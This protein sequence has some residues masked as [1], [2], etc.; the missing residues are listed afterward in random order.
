V[1]L[2]RSSLQE[3]E[4]PF[5]TTAPLP[6]CGPSVYVIM[7]CHREDMLSDMRSTE[8]AAATRVLPSQSVIAL[9]ARLRIDRRLGT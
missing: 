8:P 4:A 3:R 6:V 2:T 7:F 1:S 9:V 5:T